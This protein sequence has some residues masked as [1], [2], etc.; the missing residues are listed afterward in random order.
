MLRQN[1]YYNK[2]MDGTP[3]HYVKSSTN[4]YSIKLVGY[5]LNGKITLPMCIWKGKLQKFP[6]KVSM[7]I[8]CAMGSW[9]N[10]QQ[11]NLATYCDKCILAMYYSHTDCIFVLTGLVAS[12]PIFQ[13]ASVKNFFDD[14]SQWNVR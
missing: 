12:L 5:N 4:S 10:F 9:V 13:R 1:S 14:E 3:P 2:G 7:Y 8:V 11:H 6:T